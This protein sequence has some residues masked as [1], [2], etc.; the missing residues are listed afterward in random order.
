M[1]ASRNRTAF[2]DYESRKSFDGG[3]LGGA[4]ALTGAIGR[5]VPAAIAANPGVFAA[6]AVFVAAVAMMACYL[7][8]RRAA[9]MDPMGALREE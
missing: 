2:P 5:S 6:A 9:R 4:W 3:P 7:P 8:A 1:R